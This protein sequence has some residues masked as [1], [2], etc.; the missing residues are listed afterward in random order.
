MAKDIL[1]AKITFYDKIK[2]K[3]IISSIEDKVKSFL[4]NK[5]KVSPLRKKTCFLFKKSWMVIC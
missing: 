4:Q 2:Q 5:L 1:K 3:I